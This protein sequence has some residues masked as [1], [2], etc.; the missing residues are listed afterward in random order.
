MCLTTNEFYIGRTCN[1]MGEAM[2]RWRHDYNKGKNCKV[3]N[4]MKENGGWDNF[5]FIVLEEVKYNPNIWITE[6]LKQKTQHYIDELKPSLNS[7]NLILNY[8]RR[9]KR[10]REYYER[11][12]YQYT[13]E[14]GKELFNTSKYYHDKK[15]PS[16]K[17]VAG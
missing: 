7:S 3:I 17:K 12:K 13:C 2:K 5:Q 11:N 15:C 16:K 9:L 8:E 14:C 10:E 6:E 4:Y 1:S